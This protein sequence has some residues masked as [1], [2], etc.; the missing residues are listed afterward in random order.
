MATETQINV[1]IRRN[2]GT[3]GTRN[4]EDSGTV[5]YQSNLTNL[6]WVDGS[7]YAIGQTLPY[8]VTTSSPH[9]YSVAAIAL[10]RRYWD[11]DWIYPLS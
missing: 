6:Y 11:A 7:T 4:F 2:R 8:D 3:F 5:P 9:Y 10:L 1:G